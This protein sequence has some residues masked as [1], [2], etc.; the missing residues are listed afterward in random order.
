MRTLK[1]A[2]LGLINRA[3]I[4]GYDLSKEFEKG[5]VNFWYAKHS[6]IY[7][8]LKKLVDE[9]LIQFEIQITGE[10]LEKKIYSITEAGRKDLMQWILLDEALEPT[11][12]DIFK[13]R[14]YFSENMT[15]EQLKEQLE[16]QYKKKN[17][18]YTI[19]KKNLSYYQ[20]I[21]P[22][23]SAEFG[24]YMVLSSANFREEAYLRWLKS[25]LQQ[26]EK[27]TLE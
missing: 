5:L 3:P 17:E 14:L 16:N 15:L 7:P 25:C 4:T 22:I 2:I 26:L 9:G 20:C 18:K 1:Y 27:Q 12:K 8:E 19:L 21:P 10:V 24:D 23:G 11:P 13:L 6:Q